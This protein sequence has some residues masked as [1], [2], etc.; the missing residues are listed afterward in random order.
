[1]EIFVKSNPSFTYRK[2]VMHGHNGVTERLEVKEKQSID[3]RPLLGVTRVEIL[4]A[5]WGVTVAE[6]LHDRPRLPE[7]E[8]VVVDDWQ[9]VAG[10]YLFV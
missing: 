4:T 7:D 10:I 1:M 5:R 2:L 3:G 6:V 8:T 9:C